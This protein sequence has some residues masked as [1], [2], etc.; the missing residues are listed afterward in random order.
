MK[1]EHVWRYTLLGTVI[2]VLA[3]F[4]VWQTIRIQLNPEQ[5]QRFITDG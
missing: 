1:S 2:S 3:A 4:V 5:V